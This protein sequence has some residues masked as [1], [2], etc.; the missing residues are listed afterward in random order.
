M[1]AS[2]LA[3]LAVC[4]LTAIPADAGKLNLP[5][6]ATQGLRLIYSGDPDAA[7]A[8]FHRLEQQQPERPLG[9]L[10]EA[11][12]RWWKLYCEACEIK[13]GM[14]DAWRRSRLPQDDAYLALADKA[15]HLAEGHLKQNDTAEMQ[16]YAGMA[17]ALKARLLG[18]RDDRRATARAGVKAREHFLRAVQLDPDLAD[19]YTGLGLYNYYV[20]T[21]SS[22]ARVLRFFMGI[23]GGNKKE[24]VRQLELGMNRGELT[25]IEARFYLAKNLRNYDQKYARAAELLAPLVE[26]YPQNPLFHLL[27]GDMYAKLHRPEAAAASFHSAQKLEIHDAACRARVEHVVRAALAALGAPLPLLR[28][29]SC[30]RLVPARRRDRRSAPAARPRRA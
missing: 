3:L 5:T 20:D 28:T 30:G 13:Y 24:G 1:S 15:V 16:L 4:F 21:L 6:E 19:A 22:L 2:L 11:D 7:I 12:A 18:L 10:L 26:R 17:W 25:A 14:I 27:L 29:T 8:L 23:P 9:F